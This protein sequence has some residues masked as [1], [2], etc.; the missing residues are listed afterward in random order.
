MGK[1]P[2][3]E[4]G[5]APTVEDTE[6]EDTEP[7]DSGELETAG[8]LLALLAGAG[9]GGADAQPA[10]SAA[11]T[12]PATHAASPRRVRLLACWMGADTRNSSRGS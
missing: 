5:G 1:K 4:P 11:V 10:T 6:L 3:S 9:G 8:P 7:E 2:A 12:P